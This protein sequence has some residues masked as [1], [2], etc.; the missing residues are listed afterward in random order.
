MRKRWKLESANRKT[1]YWVSL[2]VF[3]FL[4]VVIG[5]AF[6][7]VQA[8]EKNGQTVKTS[9]DLGDRFAEVPSVE[10][11]GEFYRPYENITNVLVLGVDRYSDTEDT[12]ISYRNGGQSDFLLLLAI[13][14]DTQ[15]VT[16]IQIDR[17]TMTKITIL[18]VLGDVTGTRV[19]QIC[20]SHGFGDGKERSCQLTE[21]AVSG[22]LG[23]IDIDF[24]LAMEMD[25][26]ASLN[27]ALGGITVTL[28]DDFSALDPSMVIG[29]T[30][31]LQGI[32]AEYYVRGRMYIGVGTNAARMGR[33]REFMAALSQRFTER[34]HE[35]GNADFI[36]DLLDQLAPY[37][38]TDMSRGRMINM[39]WNARNYDRPDPLQPQGQYEIGAYGYN[40]FHV[41]ETSLKDIEMQTFYYPVEE[42]ES[43][44]P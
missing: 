27:D 7:V 11:N 13:N 25:G 26:I 24:Y 40:E 41:N 22:L 21:N 28:E 6:W 33:Q 43:D 31:T 36:G 9:G 16:S 15:T 5:F 29:A 8:L 17:D 35:D 20:L 44:S 32:Q 10:Y 14:D 37:L 4:I 18:G 2:A 30:L 3:V 12:G 42:S 39:V 19:A 23:G 34:L 38:T 1:V